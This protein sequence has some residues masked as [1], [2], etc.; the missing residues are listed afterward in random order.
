MALTLLLSFC[1]TYVAEEPQV[2]AQK[3]PELNYLLITN[4]VSYSASKKYILKDLTWL[5]ENQILLEACIIFYAYI[6][7]NQA[8]EIADPESHILT[9]KVFLR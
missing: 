9:A 7:N 5:T 4:A 3:L 2:M 8:S 6:S 1:A